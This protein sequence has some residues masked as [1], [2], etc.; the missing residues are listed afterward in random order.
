M[1]AKVAPRS[2]CSRCRC[3]VESNIT[4]VS[5]PITGYVICVAAR[6]S[7]ARSDYDFSIWDPELRLHHGHDR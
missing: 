2:L 7:V 3:C 6:L 1:T 5:L 4:F